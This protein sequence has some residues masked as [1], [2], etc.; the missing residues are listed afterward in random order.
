MWT[1]LEGWWWV[2]ALKKDEVLEFVKSMRP[3]DHVILFYSNPEDK[4]MVLFT[5]LKAGLSR[6]EAAVYVASQEAPEEIEEA[7]KRFNIDVE[8]Y[9]KSGALKVISYKDWYFRGGRFNAAETMELWK[10]LYEEALAKGFKGLRVTGETSCFFEKRRVKELLAYEEALHR[11][12]E[13]PIAAICAYD[14]EVVAQE[15]DGKLFLDLIQAHSTVI[16]LGPK[17]GVVKS[18]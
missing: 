17:G 16:I 8:T 12:L 15:R 3:R 14:T 7:M 11:V 1:R 4:R 13:I 10:N 5:Y 9:E 6:G 18:Q 2:N